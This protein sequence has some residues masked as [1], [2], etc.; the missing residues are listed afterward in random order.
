MPA[1]GVHHTETNDASWDG[2]GNVA[3][4]RNDENK[5]YYRKMYAWVDPDGDPETK[6]AYKFPNHF[7]NED[8]KVGAA[9]VKGCQSG[10]AVLNGAMGGAKIPS[11]DRQGVYNHLAAHLRD[12]EVEPAELREQP[13]QESIERR[14]MPIEMRID[15][16][17][18]IEGYA[19]V[20]NQWSENLGFFREKVRKGAFAKTIQESDIRALFN[21]DPNYVLGRTRSDTLELMEDNKGLEF[22]LKPPNTTYANDLL[23]S[24]DRKDI[25]QA[26]FG[27]ETIKDEWNRNADPLERELI[28][29]KLFD[30]SVVTYPAY[31]QT[32]VSARN[33][34]EM[35]IARVQHTA[36]YDEVRFMLDQLDEILTASKP[37]QEHHSEDDQ[38]QAVE[39]AQAR[40]AIRKRAVELE[41]LKLV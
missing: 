1:I 29:V 36:N 10:I 34:A 20:F 23:E 25:D 27:F 18:V 21:H 33:L 14:Y 28:E 6:A 40:A 5:A 15:D 8:G 13:L 11:G 37:E 3:R 17:G 31:P 35:F 22:R 24:I 41:K 30:V 9:S 12:A 19:A 4:L 2:P 32:N 16:E 26:S 38:E 39:A 7:V